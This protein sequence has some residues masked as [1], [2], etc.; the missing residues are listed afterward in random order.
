MYLDLQ[1]IDVNT[2]QPVP[3][4]YMDIW[5]GSYSVYTLS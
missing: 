2:C 5:H 3:G 4:I 1:F